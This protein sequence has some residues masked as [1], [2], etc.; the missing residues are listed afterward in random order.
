[1]GTTGFALALRLVPR[2]AE[3]TRSFFRGLVGALP[4]YASVSI[5]STLWSVYPAWTL[6]ESLE[7]FVDVALLA[8]I[9]SPFAQRTGTRQS[10][11]GRGYRWAG[12]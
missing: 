12:S 11:I 4:I 10:S 5:V 2:Q 9:L 1:M 7:Y 6:Y 3:W 8:A